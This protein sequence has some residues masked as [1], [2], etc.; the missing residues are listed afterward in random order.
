MPDFA[1][2]RHVGAGFF[3]QVLLAHDRAVNELRA[4]K[5]ISTARVINPNFYAEA[6]ALSALQHP[7]IVHVKDAGPLP[8]GN[9]YI[10]ME[11]LQNGSIEGR[12]AAGDLRLRQAISYAIDA[13][14]GLEYA[15]A[16]QYVHRDIKPGNIMI[17]DA[18]EGKLSDFGL[19]EKIAPRVDAAGLGYL[20]HR[21]PEMILHNQANALTDIYAMGVTLYRMVNGIASPNFTYP[22]NLN[23]AIVRGR[24]PNRSGYG[25]TIPRSLRAVINKAMNTDPTRR[26]QS[27]S[28]LRHALEQQHVLCDWTYASTASSDTWKGSGDDFVCEVTGREQPTRRLGS[29]AS[30]GSATGDPKARR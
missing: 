25:P 5:F 7:N 19:A 13:C 6:Q 14:R 12:L 20:T 9:T 2:I 27:A 22:G 24:F 17:G 8:G 16:L 11:W 23:D 29:R 21:A 3:G 28:D 4:V 10:A 26:Y 18:G 1:W 15:H 30:A